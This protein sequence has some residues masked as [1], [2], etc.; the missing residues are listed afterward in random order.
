M[1][2]LKIRAATDA[3]LEEMRRLFKETVRNIDIADYNENQKEV[4][5]S[6]IDDANLLK[7]KLA[8]EHFFVAAKDDTLYGFASI[9]DEGYIDFVYVHK[10]HQREGVAKKLYE[11]LLELA[12]ERHMTELTVK[13]SVSARPFFEHLG[14][15]KRGM[16]M[17]I[18]QGIRLKTYTMSLII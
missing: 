7:S 12:K 5:A 17:N 14:F 2:E 18:R 15:E 16:I 6:T 9:T 10:D 4:W 8:T 1:S 3:D 11:R 13:A